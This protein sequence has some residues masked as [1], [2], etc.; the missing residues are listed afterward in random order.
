LII[1]GAILDGSNWNEEN[2]VY[3]EESKTDKTELSKS[4]DFEDHEYYSDDNV[5]PEGNTEHTTTSDDSGSVENHALEIEALKNSMDTEALLLAIIENSDT[6]S[7]AEAIHDFDGKTGG[8]MKFSTGNRMKIIKKGTMWW[9]AVNLT[10]Q[11]IGWIPPNYVKEEAA[12][13][14]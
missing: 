12:Q 13:S 1:Q 2:S 3:L 8:S 7:Y 9:L 6:I 11:D 14:K 4:V 10:E 5:R